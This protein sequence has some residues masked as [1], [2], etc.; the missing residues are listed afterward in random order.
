MVM[1]N[2][3]TGDFPAGR[4]GRDVEVASTLFL[5]VLE[6]IPRHRCILDIYLSYP[7]GALD[8]NQ[9]QHNL[10][11]RKASHEYRPHQYC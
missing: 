10:T 5:E 7:G 6:V 3:V 11:E 4:D 9:C 1:D 8:Y 2:H